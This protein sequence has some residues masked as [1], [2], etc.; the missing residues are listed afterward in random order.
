MESLEH[1]PRPI[2]M[3]PVVLELNATTKIPAW[4]DDKMVAI[5][6]D[7]LLGSIAEP[8]AVSIVRPSNNKIDTDY[9]LTLSDAG[10]NT[11]LLMASAIARVV[12]VPHTNTAAWLVGSLV[13]LTRLGPGAVTV[14]GAANVTLETSGSA[15]GNLPLNQI[16]W[17]RF[18]GTTGGVNF[19]TLTNQ[20]DLANN[21][22]DV[23]KPVSTA[24]Q[25]AL[26]GKQALDAQLSSTIP[27]N[28]KSANYTLVA[29]DSAKHI[30]HPASDNN[31]RTFTIPANSSVAFAIGTV[32]MFINKINVVTIA[33]NSDTLTLADLGTTG[34]RLLSAN[35]WATAVKISTT[36]W[37]ISGP[38]LN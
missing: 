29:T 31:P 30:F 1:Y 13:P 21:T 34:S 18:R 3:L 14:V 37:I 28:S 6:V 36:E 23:A 7:N 12:T 10:A 33:I 27:Q 19:W 16:N 25:T 24:T 38:G 2:S 32:L 4:Q 9:T 20:L 26:N 15:S 5:T 8:E 17:L 11:L 35:G 22:S